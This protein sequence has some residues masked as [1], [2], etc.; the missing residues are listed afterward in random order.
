MDKII[1]LQDYKEEKAKD[2]EELKKIIN[3]YKF[4]NKDLEQQCN[5]YLEKYLEKIKG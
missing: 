4:Y 2:I 5:Y 3:S 1:N